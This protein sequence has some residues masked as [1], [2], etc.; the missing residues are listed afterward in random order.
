[1]M[2]RKMPLRSADV[3]EG[4]CQMPGMLERR[5]SARCIMTEN[6]NA[7]MTGN[8]QMTAHHI[9]EGGVTLGSPHRG[10]MAYRPEQEACVRI[11]Q[12]LDSGFAN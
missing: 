3:V 2:R 10:R 7:E 1:M 4:E 5:Y 9:H 12:K 8:A 6:S 11:S